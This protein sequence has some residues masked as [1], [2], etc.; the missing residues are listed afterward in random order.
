MVA[1][2]NED[3]VRARA[4]KRKRQRR[5]DMSAEIDHW[6]QRRVIMQSFKS[7]ESCFGQKR[8]FPGGDE[9]DDRRVPLRA[10]SEAFYPLKSPARRVS[11]RDSLSLF[12]LHS[13]LSSFHFLTLVQ[14]PTARLCPLHRNGIGVRNRPTFTLTRA[15]RLYDSV[16]RTSHP[17]RH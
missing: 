10:R 6:E 14:A 13:R 8:T 5:A 12:K 3:V 1:F 4:R 17:H 16:T 7:S 2:N 11:G 9:D 15:R